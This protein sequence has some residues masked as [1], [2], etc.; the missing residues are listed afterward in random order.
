MRNHARNRG[1]LL[2]NEQNDGDH[3]EYRFELAVPRSGDNLPLACGDHAHAAHDEFASNDNKHGPTWQR[4]Q[5]NKH[6]Q[7]CNDENLIGQ[8]IHEFAEVGN[9]A[10]RTSEVSIKPIGARDH[11]KD[12]RGNPCLPGIEERK[13]HC[14]GPWAN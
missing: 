8:R 11:D 14:V 10:S 7:R 1:A 2:H 5:F 6:K 4:P 12:N 13:S 3:L 9:F